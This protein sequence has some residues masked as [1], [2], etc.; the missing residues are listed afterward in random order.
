M[1]I[2][3]QKFFVLYLTHLDLVGFKK[4]KRAEERAKESQKATEK[5]HGNYAWKDL[6]ED[7]IKLKRLQVPEP[8]KYLKH[9]RLDKLASPNES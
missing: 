9:H 7:P 5:T 1:F 2:V 8:N 4:K 6:C 3:K